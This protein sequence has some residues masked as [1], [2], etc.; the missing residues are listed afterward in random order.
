MEQDGLWQEIED[1][2]RRLP[3]LFNI[4]SNDENQHL[5]KKQKLV[6]MHTE[7]M[8]N[9]EEQQ[10]YYADDEESDAD[11]EDE[12]GNQ[13]ELPELNHDGMTED[14]LQQQ[15]QMQHKLHQRIKRIAEMELFINKCLMFDGVKPI[16]FHESRKNGN[17]RIIVE[18]IHY[19]NMELE[20]FDEKSSDENEGE[21]HIAEDANDC[22]M[23]L[24]K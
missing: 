14:I 5:A 13:E 24:A 20:H 11:T 16:P 9:Y 19:E 18:K 6:E 12:H 8:K 21:L 22:S 15:P 7:F 23:E 4:Q 3:E 17:G 1:D 10:R 2:M